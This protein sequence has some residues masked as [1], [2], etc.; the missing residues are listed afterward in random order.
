MPGLLALFHH[1]SNC[2]IKI[3]EWNLRYGLH[4][5]LSTQTGP[6]RTSVAPFQPF[7]RV[8]MFVCHRKY[9]HT[10]C[11]VLGSRSRSKL[12]PA[13]KDQCIFLGR[14]PWIMA[15]QNETTTLYRLIRFLPKLTS[16]HKKIFKV[17]FAWRQAVINHH[18]TTLTWLGKLA[19]QIAKY[20]QPFR[21]FSANNRIKLK[22]TSINMQMACILRFRVPTRTEE[23]ESTK[24]KF[25][26]EYKYFMIMLGWKTR[27]SL[28]IKRFFRRRIAVS[29]R[30]PKLNASQ[31]HCNAIQ[32]VRLSDMQNRESNVC[33]RL[34]RRFSFCRQWIKCFAKS[35]TTRRKDKWYEHGREKKITPNLTTI[36][37]K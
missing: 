28:S 8:G 2:V 14:L 6:S 26:T 31:W 15:K 11:S 16:S 17:G 29:S 13:N 34:D 4:S 37:S 12:N 1:Y 22:V 30:F 3:S 32:S 5:K 20:M 19:N 23:M 18:K 35:T 9:P 27:K 21:R 24:Y 10:N 7:E 25:Q 36:L 33:I